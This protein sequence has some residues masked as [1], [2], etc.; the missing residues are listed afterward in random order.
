MWDAFI[1]AAAGLAL[2][3]I[4][5]ARIAAQEAVGVDIRDFSFEPHTAAVSAGTAIRWVNRDDI[6]HQILMEG[7]RPGSSG[8]LAPGASHTFVFQEAGRFT[9][10]C[11]IH[12]TMLGEIVVTG[13]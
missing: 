10:R 7:G 11:G 5:P 1:L 4:G 13:P 2:F 9:Y 12:P 3:M 8:T 6:P